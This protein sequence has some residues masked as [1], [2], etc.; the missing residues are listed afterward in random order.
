MVPGPALRLRIQTFIFVTR[1]TRVTDW[2]IDWVSYKR[3]KTCAF[4]LPYMYDY[5]RVHSYA[6]AG[7]EDAANGSASVRLVPGVAAG[8]WRKRKKEA[9]WSAVM[10]MRL[11]P[12][13]ARPRALAR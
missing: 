7:H 9:G 3:R 2:V 1:G 5:F 11:G 8:T 4:T 13:V 12:R 10:K 6:G